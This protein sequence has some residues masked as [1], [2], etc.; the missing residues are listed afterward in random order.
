MH[1]HE[2]CIGAACTRQVAKA[3]GLAGEIDAKRER[4]LTGELSRDV[5]ARLSRSYNGVAVCNLQ[6]GT[7]RGLAW[8]GH[9]WR[10]QPGAGLHQQCAPLLPKVLVEVRPWHDE[11]RPTMSN[12]GRMQ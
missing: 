4:E 9:G 7:A 2:H 10:L 6:Q 5:A 1:T 11:R 8:M 3:V 12:E